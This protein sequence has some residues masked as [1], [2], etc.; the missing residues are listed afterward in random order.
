MDLE[1]LKKEA[2][3]KKTTEARLC[4]LAESH[5]ELARAIAKRAAPATLA[6]SLILSQQSDVPTQRAQL[7]GAQ[8]RQLRLCKFLQRTR[9][10]WSLK[11]WPL[12]RMHLIS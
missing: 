5:V 4:E 6:L 11:P 9:H 7:P 10:L 1:A 12:I 2:R 3:H 8:I